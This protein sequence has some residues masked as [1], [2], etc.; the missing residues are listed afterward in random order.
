MSSLPR[1]RTVADVM[2][3]TVHFATPS[4]PFKQLV[5][6]IQENRISA[7]PIVDRNGIPIGIVSE[8]DLLV[9][10]RR[11]EIEAQ[12]PWHSRPLKAKAEA[13][14]AADVMT[15]P[16]I[17]VGL[18]TAIPEAA[19][20]MQERNVRRLVVV[21]QRRCIAGI[22]TRSD[23][24]QIFMRTDEDLRGE[25]VE[26]IIPAVIPTQFGAVEVVVESNIIRLSGEVDRRSDAEILS[27]LSR[28]VDGVVDVVNSLTFRWDDTREFPRAI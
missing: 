20:I 2:T 21:D 23:L 16:V 4:T 3:T 27:R 1:H 8:T 11:A 13:V 14:I 22:V 12:A 15:S 19:R 26:R 18:D 24:L 10:E 28:D 25:I 17:T 6:L 9:K 5:R 7:V